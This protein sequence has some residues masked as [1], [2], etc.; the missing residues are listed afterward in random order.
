[1]G[2]LRQTKRGAES[3]YG[4]RL[5]AKDVCCLL[6]AQEW[7]ERAIERRIGQRGARV[8]RHTGERTGRESAREV[9]RVRHYDAIFRKQVRPW[10]RWMECL[11]L[12]REC[13]DRVDEL[14]HSELD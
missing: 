9:V 6:I 3:P 11:E 7:D 5:C 14:G 10:R 13:L 1:V 8:Q 2:V 12:P 4:D